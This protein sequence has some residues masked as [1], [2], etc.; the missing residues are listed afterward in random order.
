VTLL[1]WSG[2]IFLFLFPRASPLAI[3]PYS[4]PSTIVSHTC[5]HVAR[6]GAATLGSYRW[7]DS[8]LPPLRHAVPGPPF[9]SSTWHPQATPLCAQSSRAQSAFLRHSRPT[10]ALAEIA[11]TPAPGQLLPPQRP[12]EI[13][14]FPF[15]PRRGEQCHSGDSSSIHRLR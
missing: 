2:P 3:S 12:T 8:P 5:S 14:A 11:S 10:R 1:P 9:P 4:P 13:A 6:P 15:V 7:P